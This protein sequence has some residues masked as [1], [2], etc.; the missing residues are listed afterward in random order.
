MP[1]P[2][3]AVVAVDQLTE[4]LPELEEEL[5]EQPVTSSAV[6]VNAAS[7]YLYG[8]LTSAS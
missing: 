8:D 6:A 7:A 3:A 1:P 5:D 2:A 4:L